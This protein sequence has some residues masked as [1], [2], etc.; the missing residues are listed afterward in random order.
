MAKR[1]GREWT[2]E[3]R[4]EARERALARGF[5]KKAEVVTAPSAEQVLLAKSQDTPAIHTE[6]DLAAVAGKD[7]TQGDSGTVTHTT[8]GKVRVY[9][10][11]PYGYRAREIPVTNYSNALRN[12]FRAECPDCG[13]QCGDGINDCPVREKRAYRMCPI[14][15]CGKKVYD[16]ERTEIEAAKGDAGDPHMIQDDAYIEATPQLRTKAALDKHM[17]GRHPIEAAAAGIVAP[18]LREVKSVRAV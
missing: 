9:K 7:V 15:G 5:G 8:P 4:R 10:P 13:G 16:Y 12:G 3:Q 18:G 14:P 11:T 2:E 6:E 17:L 1:K